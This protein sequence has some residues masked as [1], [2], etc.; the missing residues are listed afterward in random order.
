MSIHLIV[1]TDSL[2]SPL[3]GIGY[4]TAHL[5]DELLKDPEI[6]GL[7]GLDHQGLI[8]EDTLAQRIYELTQGELGRQSSPSRAISPTPPAEPF[9]P[10]RQG[11][12]ITAAKTLAK[13]IPGVYA[14]A[15]HWYAYRH[16]RVMA[17]VLIT[18][19]GPSGLLHA[20]N[21]I[22]PVHTGPTVITIHD[23]S[24]MRHP[25]THP[26]ARIDWLNEHLPRAIKQADQ[27]ISVSEFTR[28]ELLDLGLVDDA[29]KVTVCHNGC[30]PSFRPQNLEAIQP[31]LEKWGLQKGQYI[32]SIATLEPRKNM[33]RL[34]EAYEAL[35]DALAGSI[36]LV[37]TG[38]SGWKN[39][40][41]RQRIARIKPPRQVI[42]T[43][44]LPRSELQKLLCGAGLFAYLSIYE[45][46]G[47]P[48]IEAMA[49][50]APVLTANTTSL[51][52]VAGDCG[53]TVDPLDIVAIR[54][55]LQA[56]LENRHMADE[57]R[58][59][60]L[61]R[62]ALFSWRRCAIETIEVY[63]KALATHSTPVQTRTG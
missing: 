54:D 12:L 37:L 58:I 43:G 17:K 33:E 15:K 13:K 19:N 56:L 2:A 34:L 35:P 52:E 31:E 57:Y 63:K 62:A 26:Q 7:R 38:P 48:V 30:D 4:Y 5:V 10:N 11:G 50:G 25:E 39:K 53:Y 22:P 45:G 23:L 51:R 18:D 8:D 3:T 1:S 41:L 9:N 14:L 40:T 20:P 55:A 46:F 24:H 21:Y 36:P 29:N 47:L 27:I 49:C 6:N 44:Y 32:L 59:K 61:H 42:T 28:R 16:R 60:G